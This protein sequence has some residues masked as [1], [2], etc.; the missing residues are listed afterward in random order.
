M[1]IL[2]ATPTYG[3][4]GTEHISAMM[5]LQG[6]L[7]G[8]GV[9]VRVIHHA[10]A[11]VARSRNIIA[12]HFWE[13]SELTHL[14]FVDS[15]M[16][17]EPAAVEALIRADKPFVGAVY[18]KRQIDFARLVA[19]ARKYEDMAVIMASALDFVVTPGS[20]VADVHDGRCKVH[21]VGMGLCL[22]RREV[23]AGLLGSGQIRQ[24]FAGAAVG[25]HR[26]P[27]LG[28]FDPIPTETGFMP[29]DLSFCRRWRELCGG[30][31]WAVLDQEIGH[32]GTMT[33]KGRVMDVLAL[34][35]EP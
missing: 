21:G 23:F 31:V 20:E 18:P 10:M 24:D 4:V 5:R 22:I 26:G 35:P 30:E 1:Q 19:A 28:F 33:Y 25:R 32:V 3:G 7:L 9:Q 8:R 17:F 11:E 2:L 16:S 29:E 14:L 27:T 12:T 6:W 34:G 13:N 15:D